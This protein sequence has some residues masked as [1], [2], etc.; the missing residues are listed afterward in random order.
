[1]NN[2]PNVFFDYK[3][4]KLSLHPTNELIKDINLPLLYSQLEILM[5]LLLPA[6]NSK[7]NVDPNFS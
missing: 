3:E 5:E 2:L 1:M 6:M 4:Y 7:D